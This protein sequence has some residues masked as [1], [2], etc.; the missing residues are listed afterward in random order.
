MHDIALDKRLEADT[1]P[2]TELPL[3]RVLLM[4]D[5]RVP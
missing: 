2:V 5:T 4:D 3:C 1:L